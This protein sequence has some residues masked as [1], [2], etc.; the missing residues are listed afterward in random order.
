MKFATTFLL[1]T[2]LVIALP[3]EDKKDTATTPAP[4]VS[5]IRCK[6]E[7]QKTSKDNTKNLESCDYKS[8][9]ADKTN[10]ILETLGLKSE[11][12]EQF[13]KLDKFIAKCT[14]TPNT[15][16]TTCVEKC[17]DKKKKEECT[18]KCKESMMTE[19]GKCAIKAADK[20]DFDLKEAAECSSKCTQ[21]TLPEVFKCDYK[22][23]KEL[24]DALISKASDSKDEKPKDDKTKEEGKDDKTKDEK[25]KDDKTKDEK[26]KDEKDKSEKSSAMT[27]FGVSSFGAIAFGTV[28]FS[29]LV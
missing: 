4:C 11:Q 25:S 8:D 18:K 29:L 15:T 23:N 22:C 7:E 1:L 20:P 27:N 6:I 9:E 17:D 13:S 2:S 24:Y 26:P 28:I 14:S 19:I 10:C 16:F 21:A 5:V 12:I 3:S